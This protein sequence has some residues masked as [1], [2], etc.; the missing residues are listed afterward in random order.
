MTNYKEILRLG[1]LGLNNSQI[2]EGLDVSRTTVIAIL[3]KTKEKGLTYEKASKLTNKELS[4]LIYPKGE[5]K[6]G[7]KMPD[8]EYVHKEMSKSGTNLTLLW[9]EYCDKCRE[10]GEIPYK[11][12]Q[13]NKYYSDY[14]NKT[15]AT[16]HIN[17]KPGELMEVDW[18]GQTAKLVNTDTGGEIKAYIFVATLPYSG[19][20]YV[21][22]FLS[23][24]QESWTKG[25]VNAYQFFGGSTR[26][27]V[28][29][30]LKTGVA[31]VTKSEIIIN[32]TYQELA[33]YYDTAVIPAR[34]RKP[35]DKA[36]VEGVV[37]IISTWIL[38]AI[39]K[40]EFFSLVD[41]NEV[42]LEKLND[43]NN[44][45]FQK[46]E[47]S[48]R[49]LFE[50]EKMF[51]QPLPIHP[52]E[53]AKWKIATV[54]YNYHVYVE[55]ENYSVPYEYIKCNVDVRISKNT[56]EVFYEGN[57]ICSHRRLYGRAN[58]YSTLE[59]HMPQEHKKYI[60][61]NGER[62]KS[63]AL[64][65]GANTLKVVENLMSTRKI[66]EQGY[67]SC[68]ALLKLSDKYSV[69][70]LEAACEKALTFTQNPSYKSIQMILA[71]G[72]DKIY[73]TTDT[74]QSLP[75]DSEHSFTRGAGYYK[76]GDEEC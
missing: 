35:K 43:F 41:L 17:R 29:D 15:K 10:A 18:A 5:P 26:I 39:R 2:A 16:M 27:L 36:M 64:K 66:E 44:K 14:V 58:Q 45:P 74:A 8:Y 65:I 53:Y 69:K 46:K 73:E 55:G 50:E 24:D 1:S 3:K 21:E 32:K 25:H 4:N 54:Q 67:K 71:T 52:F 60:E 9:L 56:V 28:P 72:K 49:S 76:R 70:R 37:G 30:N 62:F 61:W 63:W 31:K 51:L 22:A 19:Y 33:E 75:S 6:T 7:Y 11:S 59:S 38:A 40:Q 20:S 47:G 12:T 68:M 42:I 34:V 57:R 23:Q 48:R 13:F